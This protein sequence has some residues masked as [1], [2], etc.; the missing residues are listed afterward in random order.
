MY[1]FSFKLSGQKNA[2]KLQDVLNNNFGQKDRHQGLF[3]VWN[4]IFRVGE[5]FFF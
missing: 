3:D 4:S 1:V 2:L 5:E